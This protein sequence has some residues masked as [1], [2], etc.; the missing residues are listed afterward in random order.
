MENGLQ[1]NSGVKALVKSIIESSE[2]RIQQKLEGWL[3]PLPK[4][5]REQMKPFVNTGVSKDELIKIVKDLTSIS[6]EVETKKP[7]PKPAEKKE[8]EYLPY[9]NKT[10]PSVYKEG[11]VL[12]H[13][14]FKH[15]YVLLEDKGAYW[16]CALLTSNPTC[17]EVLEVCQSRFFTNSYFTRV[18][19]TVEKP[20]GSFIYPYENKEHLEE[21]KNKLKQ[22]L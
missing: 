8:K 16:A 12:M 19:L 21:I 18:L 14:I 22:I 9:N 5:F 20:Y 7:E 3:G 4:E 6:I 2:E 1:N 17:S 15:P 10:A 13:P 11:D